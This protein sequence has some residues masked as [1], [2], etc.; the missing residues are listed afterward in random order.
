VPVN[1]VAIELPVLRSPFFSFSIQ[2][3][4]GSVFSGFL[5]SFGSVAGIESAG[6]AMI[7]IVSGA[8]ISGVATGATSTGFFLKNENMASFYNQSIL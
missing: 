7:S 3:L 8:A 4:R 5:E 6:G 1:T 2:L